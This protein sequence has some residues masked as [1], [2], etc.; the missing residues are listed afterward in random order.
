M[1]RSKGAPVDSQLVLI[2]PPSMH[3]ESDSAKTEQPTRHPGW[4][5]RG[6]VKAENGATQ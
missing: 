6:S 3:E 2:V 1:T 5:V 4:Q